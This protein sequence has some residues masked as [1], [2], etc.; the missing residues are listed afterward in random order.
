M[1]EPPQMAEAV[2]QTC[3]AAAL[4]GAYA[5]AGLS[6]LCQEGRWAYA[7]DA[8]RGLPRRPLV[9]ALHAVSRE[10]QGFPHGEG[11]PGQVRG[12]EEN[13]HNGSGRAQALPQAKAPGASGTVPILLRGMPSDGALGDL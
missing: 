7:V 2:R 5:E 3:L 9:Q 13:S 10:P 1:E 11:A 6:G 4:A 8:M 12:A